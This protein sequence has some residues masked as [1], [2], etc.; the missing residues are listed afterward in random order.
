MQC[1]QCGKEFG[2]QR[3]T[4]KY[5]SDKCRNANRPA[6][7]A[8]VKHIPLTEPTDVPLRYEIVE[9]V[10]VYSREAVRYDLRE[11]WDLRPK[12]NCPN[13]KPKPKNRGRYIRVDGS[14]YQIDAVGVAHEVAA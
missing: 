4:A 1:K 7:V 11:A 12:P 10:R 6:K 9:D 2:A 13:D 14:E 5:C 3:S 8:P